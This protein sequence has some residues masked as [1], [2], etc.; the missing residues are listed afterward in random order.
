MG[1]MSPEVVQLQVNRI[2]SRLAWAQQYSSLGSAVLTPYYYRASAEG[3]IGGGPPVRR[4]TR[5]RSVGRPMTAAPRLGYGGG[6]GAGVGARYGRPGTGG[7]GYAAGHTQVQVWR[8][9]DG[10][11]DSSSRASHA[12]PLPAVPEEEPSFLSVASAVHPSSAG[13]SAAVAATNAG[14][15]PGAGGGADSASPAH[16]HLSTPHFHPR[17][18]P[19]FPGA[20]APVSSRPPTEAER[21]Q[22]RR[23]GQEEEEQYGAGA[24]GQYAGAGGAAVQAG[25]GVLA[26]PPGMHADELGEYGPITGLH[27]SLYAWCDVRRNVGVWRRVSCLA[28][29]NRPACRPSCLTNCHLVPAITWHPVLATTCHPF[30]ATPC[31]PA[32]LSGSALPH[33]RLGASR[34][35]AT[36]RCNSRNT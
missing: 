29:T 3:V 5:P 10:S 2:A 13:H 33:H 7:Q 23:W 18:A 36:A 34:V 35:G 11:E 16:S 12:A 26:A 21:R 30:L 14:G 15:W 28:Y 20:G 27:V 8:A 6:V 32:L 17:A 31:R 25:Q 22:R 24:A 19:T 4:P 9:E 1:L